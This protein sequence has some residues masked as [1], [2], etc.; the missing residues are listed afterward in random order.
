MAKPILLYPFRNRIKRKGLDPE[1]MM[2]W[3]EF[4]SPSIVKWEQDFIIGEPDGACTDILGETISGG[5]IT[6]SVASTANGICRLTT[7]GSTNNYCYV[8]PN[9]DETM[10]GA[11]YLGNNSAVMWAR[12]KINTAASVKIE[13]GFTDA[14]DD[15]GAVSNLV[16]PLTT[17]SDCA[18]WCY[19]TA[20]TGGLFWQGVYSLSSTTP[21]KYEPGIRLPVANTYE[22]LGVALLGSAV[23]FMHADAYGNP[24]GES[25]WLS[26]ATSGITADTP[27]I[28]WIG[29]HTR[30]GT[31]RLL[32]IDYVIA[33]Q[34][35]T[36]D[37][38]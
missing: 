35:R 8:F 23:K 1:E 18:L 32:D 37:D 15:E 9:G 33:Y 36:S 6:G 22:W 30:T 7:G 16:T 38:D 2:Q 29:A 34:R 14:S 12:V 10:E 19:D 3:L 27:L 13:C 28:P 17:A 24:N 25:G 5:S 11:C 4:L 20:D 31:T 26:S 21:S